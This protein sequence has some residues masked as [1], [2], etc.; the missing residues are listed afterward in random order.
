MPKPSSG[1]RKRATVVIPLAK[2]IK[3]AN[4]LAVKYGL[5]TDADFSGLSVKA[6]N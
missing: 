2:N 4:E 6:A 1:K 5:A 3:Q